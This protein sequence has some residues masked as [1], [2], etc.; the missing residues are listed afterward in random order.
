MFTF[1][2]KSGL[3]LGASTALIGGLIVATPAGA[4]DIT[5][6]VANGND[7]PITQVVLDDN[8]SV[9][10]QNASQVGTSDNDDDPVDFV[11]VTVNDGGSTVVLDEFNVGAV[12]TASY[13]F[14]VGLSGVTAWENG[15]G[16]DVN[17]AGF[18]SAVDRV[19]GSMDLRDYLAYD[20]LSSPGSG[21][22]PDFDVLFEA[23]LRNSDY[24]LV[25]ERLG[26]TFFDLVAL[27]KQGNDLGGDV[28]GFDSAYRWNSGFAPS[29]QPTQPMWFTVIDIERFGVD[30]EDEPIY[31]FRVDNDGEADVKF[32]GLAPDPFEPAMSLDKTVYAGHDSGASCGGGE[33]VDVAVGAQITYC[34]TVTNAGEAALDDLTITDADLSLSAAPIG[35]FITVSGALPLAGG[36]SIVLAYE[37]TATVTVTNT[38]TATANVLLSGGGINTVLSPETATDT[39]RV[40][41]PA[42]ASISGKVVDDNADPIAGVNITLSGTAGASTTTAADG[43]YSFTGLAAGTY[44][45]TETQPSGYADGGETAG[46]SGGTVTDD[47]IA[48][49]VLAAGDDSIDNNFDEITSSIAGTVVDSAG[50]G[51]AGVTITLEGTDDA[52]GSVSLTTTTDA[53]GDY[54]FTG[55]LSG[56]YTV[57]ETQPT[58]YDDGGETAG[59]SGGT[60]TNDVI[61][62]IVLAAGVASV[63]NDFDE[64]LRD[65]LA[66]TGSNTSL[67]V[68]FGLLFI[69][70]GAI[71]SLGASQLTVRRETAYSSA[72]AR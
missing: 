28:V 26:N 55:L 21:W 68:A 3:I 38:A 60:V 39:A 41:V 51:I 24:L 23:P 7:V 59:S 32:F 37:T 9:V 33:L 70:S 43:T 40:E 49:I 62:E 50:D 46:S 42:P 71:L 36:N 27:D 57:T 19:L 52:G 18:Q 5:I 58:G 65:E 48:G 13:N 4:A 2:R 14:P 56:T 20:T 67:V 6:N 10:T 35:D 63:G 16:T 44:T 34:F 30:T 54:S 64:V 45:V 1:I 31:G 61:S 72:S 11:S 66:N 12:S 17:T 22:N 53:N 8:G 15:S 47:Q 25:S 69:V 29:N